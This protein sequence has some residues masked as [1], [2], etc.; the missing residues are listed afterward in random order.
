VGDFATVAP[1]S[2]LS[3]GVELGTGCEIGSG[4]TTI[5]GVRIGEWTIVGA[6]AVVASDLPA[7]CTAVGVP[8]RPIK[9]R[10][11]G[12]QLEA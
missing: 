6:G 8:A 5:E 12:W 1:A 10:R 9:Q 3:G 11:S 4:V 7:N 2:N